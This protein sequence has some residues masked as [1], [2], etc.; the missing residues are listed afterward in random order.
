[1][2]IVKK[3]GRGERGEKE[4]RK[5]EREEGRGEGEKGRGEG[6][7]GRREGEER[8]GEKGE[9]DPLFTPTIKLDKLAFAGVTTLLFDIHQKI[10]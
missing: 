4:E 1:M 10:T 9:E 5:G 7:K 6:E 3:E 2:E 8:R